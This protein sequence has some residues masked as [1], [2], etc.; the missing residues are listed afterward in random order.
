VLSSEHTF[1]EDHKQKPICKHKQNQT[2]FTIVWDME[3]LGQ[4]IKRKPSVKD[5]KGFQ[6]QLLLM[7]SWNW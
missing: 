7:G 4:I 3:K 2:V 1:L 6:K 5:H